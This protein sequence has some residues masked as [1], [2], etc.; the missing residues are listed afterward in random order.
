M[1]F[2]LA[3]PSGLLGSAGLESLHKQI[4]FVVFSLM[5]ILGIGNTWVLAQGWVSPRQEKVG[6]RREWERWAQYLRR[7]ALLEEALPSQFV[8]NLHLHLYLVQGAGEEAGMVD[9]RQLAN[10]RPPQI[11]TCKK[12]NLARAEKTSSASSIPSK[13]TRSSQEP[14]C[15]L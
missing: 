9:E 11:S 8:E 2:H 7:L 13:G 3:R 1:V 4:L 12:N 6:G 14:K 15:R 10:S 5:I